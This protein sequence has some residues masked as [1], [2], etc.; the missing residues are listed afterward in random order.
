M[1]L[2]VDADKVT[3]LPVAYQARRAALIDPNDPTVEATNPAR[4][5]AAIAAKIAEINAKQEAAAEAK[6]AEIAKKA[7]AAAPPSANPDPG[8]DVQGW[9]SA[10][11]N[12]IMNI[13]PPPTYTAKTGSLSLAQINRAMAEQNAV[14][15]NLVNQYTKYLNAF[16]ALEIKPDVTQ[17]SQNINLESG[18]I[19]IDNDTDEV[20]GR[21]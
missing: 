9:L 10:M 12:A 21:L 3:S 15:A 4:A 6:K 2:Q 18:R 17:S 19:T 13:K 5:A 1:I 7:A 20:L 14:L 11:Y 16:N 8:G